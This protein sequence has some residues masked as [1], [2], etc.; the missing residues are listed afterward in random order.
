[1]FH[2][3]IVSNPPLWR[4]QK[5]C[6]TSK[7]PMFEHEIY[8]HSFFSFLDRWNHDDR[9]MSNPQ[10]Q[11]AVETKE[12]LLSH[13]GTGPPAQTDGWNNMFF[14]EL[15]HGKPPRIADHVPWVSSWIL[16]VFCLFTGFHRRVKGDYGKRVLVWF[17]FRLISSHIT[18]WNR[19][20]W[21]DKTSQPRGRRRQRIA[22]PKIPK[23]FHL[24]WFSIGFARKPTAWH[25][26]AH[27]VHT[28]CNRSPPQTKTRP[29]G[30][31]HQEWTRFRKWMMF[32]SLVL[33]WTDPTF[34][35]QNVQ[36]G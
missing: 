28:G 8:L 21:Y 24:S 30:C 7:P 3:Q 34:Q 25:G 4:E 5:P 2:S 19:K 23:I 29:C 15:T 33:N 27:R 11:Q 6:P 12:P 17:L 9:S 18:T 22:A 13:P 35:I 36:L 16:I 26:V 14:S 20:R 1:M 32:S 10:T 31:R